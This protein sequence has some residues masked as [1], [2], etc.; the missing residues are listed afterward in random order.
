[1]LTRVKDLAETATSNGEPG[2]KGKVKS[3]AQYCGVPRV[4]LTL[5]VLKPKEE[6]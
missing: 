6:P 1:M 4:G 5:Q 3:D 2:T